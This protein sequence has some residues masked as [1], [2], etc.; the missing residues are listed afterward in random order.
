MPNSVH[1][2]FSR[3]GD[4]RLCQIGATFDAKYEAFC[5]CPIVLGGYRI[6][7]RET[8]PFSKGE[9]AAA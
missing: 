8:E 1:Q 7:K 6:P 3:A 4:L 5:L 9:R 2:P